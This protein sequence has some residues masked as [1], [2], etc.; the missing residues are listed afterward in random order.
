MKKNNIGK[1]ELKITELS[2]GATSLASMPETYGYEVTEDRAQKTLKRFFQ[3]PVNML[4]TSRNYGL[5]RSEELIGQAIDN[6][7]GWPKDFILSTKLDRNMQTGHFDATQAR[8]SFEESLATLRLDSIDILHLHDPE[9]V[10]DISEITKKGGALDELFKIKEEGLVKAVGLAMGRIDIM[11]PILKD[12]DFDILINHNR[13]TLL[14]RQANEMYDYAHK[15]GIA[16]I[17]AAP[18]ASGILAKGS[19]KGKIITY[20]DLTKETL[21]PVIK[22]EKICEK[23]GI[24]MGAAALQF[25]LRDSRISTTLCGVSSPESIQKN[26]VWAQTQIPSEFWDE[27]LVLPFSTDDPEANRVFTPG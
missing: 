11:L 6:N 27:V 14:N 10:V 18:F 3:G 21:A 12:W 26:L 23:F 13:Y 19:K 1:T 20:Q 7:G 17:N 4:D 16:I 8:K 24:E 5:G 9:Y 25:S 2:F 15:K 22:I